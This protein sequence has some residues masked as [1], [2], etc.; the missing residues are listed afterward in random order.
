MKQISLILLVL[1]S[2]MMSQAQQAENNVPVVSN[3]LAD[4]VDLDQVLIRYDVEDLDG[5]IAQEKALNKQIQK[6]ARADQNKWLDNI[7]NTWIQITFE[8]YAYQ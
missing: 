4:Q 7:I 3:V 5:D 2:V 6:S 1:M 8:K